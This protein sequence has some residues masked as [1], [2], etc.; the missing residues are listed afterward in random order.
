MA[1]KA[2]I[3]I[4]QGSDFSTII[5]IADE[6]DMPIDVTGSTF[7]AIARKHYSSLTSYAFTVDIVDGPAGDIMLSMP[8]NTTAN[9]AAGRYVYDCESTDTDGIVTR[10]VEGLLT[11]SPRVKR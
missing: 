11:I 6:N 8:A 2:N 10:L 7:S 4:D 5:S 3:Q 9:I 1:I